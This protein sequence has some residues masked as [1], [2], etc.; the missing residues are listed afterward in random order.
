VV[1]LGHGEIEQ[2]GPPREIFRGPKTRFVAEFVGRN[3]ILA[4]KVAAGRMA[5]P[6]GEVPVAAPDGPVEIVIAA[7]RVTVTRDRPADRAAI[8]V[9]FLSEEFAGTGIICYFEAP[10]GTEWKAQVTETELADLTPEPGAP[11]WLSWDPARVHV[12]GGHDGT[13]PEATAAP[14]G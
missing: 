4:G 3:N 1:I 14:A 6:G 8:R 10:D 9:A 13:G 7:D 2:I 5:T 11:F 12:L